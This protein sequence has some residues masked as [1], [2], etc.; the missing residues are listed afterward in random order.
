MPSRYDTLRRRALAQAV[1]LACLGSVIIAPASAQQ[2]GSGSRAELLTE[3]STP[4]GSL[5]QVL[6]QF[7]S[8]A[9][10]L[11]AI[12]GSLTAGRTSRGLVGTYN[13]R[14]GLEAILAG[15]GLTAE[16]TAP[17]QFRLLV[18]N[19][20]TTTL[21]PIN[22]Y[23][24]R[25]AE[26]ARGP[27]EGYVAQRSATATKT[28]TSILETPQSVSVVTREQAESQGALSLAQSLRYSSGI[29]AEIRGSATRYDIPYI[30]GFGSPSDPIL[31]QDGLR[32]PRGPGYAIPQVEAYGSER[33]ELLKGPSSTLYGTAMPGGLVNTVSKRPTEEP[34]GEVEFQVG[35]NDHSQAA[36]DVSDAV[37]QDKTLLYR[38]V[39]LGKVADTQVVNTE[40]ERYYVAPSLTWRI[41]DNT[42]L[43]VLASYQKDPEGGYY[44]ILPTVGSLWDSPAGQI[45]SDFN[46][47]DPAFAEFDRE[48]YSLGYEFE[49]RF[50][51]DW[52]IRHNLR[53]L[54]VDSIT[55]DVATQSLAADGHTINRYALATDESA[56][57]LASDLQVQTNFLTGALE[58]TA[59]IGWDHQSLDSSQKRQFGMA[60]SIDYLDPQYSI[61]N[62]LVLAPFV[63][64]QQSIDQN[65]IYLQDQIRFDQW[66]LLLGGR[67]ERVHTRTDNN[68]AN[69]SQSQN[70]SEFSSKLGLLYSFD[71]GLVAYGSYSTSFLP[72]SGTDYQ[73]NALEPTTAEQYEVG[74]KYQPTG[75]DGLFTLAYF[76]ITQQDVV[77]T[78]NPLM[79]YQTGEVTSRGVEL[80]AKLE[81]DTQ[82]NLI[83]AVTYTNADISES[84]GVDR[85]DAPVAIPDY[86]ASLWIDHRFSQPLFSG[87]TVGAGARYVGESTGGYSPNAFTAGAQRLSVPDYTLLDALIRYDLS[88]LDPRLDG[89]NAQLNV[90]NLADKTYVTCLGNN[91]CNYGNG[92]SVYAT[93]KY[94]W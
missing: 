5:D 73:G 40:E 27:V 14:E 2:V 31:F 25:V 41:S 21:A 4:G 94:Q 36:L 11:L 63:D 56:T 87:L 76:D 13:V 86:T 22:I 51:D 71:N 65:G 23:A 6:N 12:D 42:D 91:F 60:P 53:Y 45:P 28:D 92:R 18:A 29:A 8:T 37:N 81:L 50:S 47:G 72:A 79:R 77:T 58:H 48:Q 15:T 57:G 78:V 59:L 1:L 26:S 64:Q 9:G 70:D 34:R 49:H 46:D 30:R 93:L 85:G 54:N 75:L 20:A 16:Q 67:Y 32:L 52:A 35:S 43:T 88:V 62:S 24:E 82:T 90:S 83:G 66:T 17:G 44:G 80:E 61:A 38:F 55:Q 74:L 39:A 19:E 68:L 10:I 69:T 7:A 84:V 3:Y 89:V 33:I